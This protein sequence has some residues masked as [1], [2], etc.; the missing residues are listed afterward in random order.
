M[1]ATNDQA[2][3]KLYG[4]PRDATEEAIVAEYFRRYEEI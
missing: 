3:L 4:L 2:V 1:N